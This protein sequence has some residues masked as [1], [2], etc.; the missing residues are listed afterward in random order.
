MLKA[1]ALA[2]GLL[3]AAIVSQFPEFT[4]QYTQRLG[5]Q[6][7]ALEVVIED[8]DASARRAEMTREEALASMG[9]SV[10]LENRRRD[11][12]NTIDRHARLTADLAAL[13]ASGPLERLTMP[14]RVADTE[15]ALST[16]HDFVP[17]LPLS[18]AGGISALVGYGLGWGLV[19][20][21]LAFLF[22]PFRR[23]RRKAGLTF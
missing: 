16:Y 14:Q 22:W 18:L 17:A 9:G 8:F 3:G 21:L 6:V 12:R 1:L 10:F 4:Q 5:G 7:E 13:R 2:G 23:G 11:M 20:A 15:L 19:S